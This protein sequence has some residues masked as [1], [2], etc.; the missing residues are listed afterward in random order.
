M[1]NIHLQYFGKE[2]NLLQS[3][4]PGE[5]FGLAISMPPK[6]PAS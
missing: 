6:A 5:V 3:H 1:I 2:I 4:N